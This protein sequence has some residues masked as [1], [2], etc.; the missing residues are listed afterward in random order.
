MPADIPLL[1]TVQ[2]ANFAADGLLR[3]D[4][5]VPEEINREVMRELDAGQIQGHAAPAGA[6][7]HTLWPDSK[8]IG[9]MLRLPQV[10]GIIQSLVGPKPLYDHHAAHRVPPK[11]EEGQLWHV[12]AII[13]T[14]IHFDIQ[15]FYFPHDT[16]REMGGT[17]FLPGSHLRR[18]HEF[19]VSRPQN[20]LGQTPVVCKAGTVL[21]GHHDL[22]HCAQP[23][24]TDTMRYM[25]KI[26]INPTVRQMLLWDTSDL[27]DPQV[28][29]I[30]ARNHGWYGEDDRL[31]VCN[32]IRLWR[33]LTADDR[34]DVQYWLTRLENQ[35]EASAAQNQ[36]A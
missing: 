17:L 18:V 22:W 7:L 23:N 8:G 27:H 9:A 3:F 31:E 34:F 24:L 16:P 30:L 5:L 21:A 26:R 14:R 1:S 2:M 13:D 11:H 20:F 19:D 4:E 15:L 36:S 10:E 33:F 12:D 28:E 32:R 25:I 29:R 6:L 35:P